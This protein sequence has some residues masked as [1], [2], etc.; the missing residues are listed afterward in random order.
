MQ[1]SKL[2]VQLFFV[3]SCTYIS[4]TS[5]YILFKISLMMIKQ[6]C[7]K[8]KIAFQVFQ[9]TIITVQQAGLI[10][11]L[12]RLLRLISVVT[13]FSRFVTNLS[14][15]YKKKQVALLIIKTARLEQN[16]TILF[17]L[18]PN[19]VTAVTIIPYSQHCSQNFHFQIKNCL[20][21]RNHLLYYSRI[22]NIYQ[23][24]GNFNTV[25][26]KQMNKKQSSKCTTIEKL[27][28]YWYFSK[29]SLNTLNLS[30]N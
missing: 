15:T 3:L 9:Q 23:Q 16:N 10:E 30:Y 8:L 6:H 29:W 19:K 17:I 27:K 14:T 26:D 5:T 22:D 7:I 20:T 4:Y 12:P 28:Y 21:A 24:L 18:A 1:Y 13:N 2:E 11:L 25:K